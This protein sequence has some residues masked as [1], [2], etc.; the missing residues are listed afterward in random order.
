MA[1]T[2]C[3]LYEGTNLHA[4]PVLAGVPFTPTNLVDDLSFF[5]R[6]KEDNKDIIVLLALAETVWEKLPR[7]KNFVI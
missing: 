6:P 5:L 1:W 2:R 3:S 4:S 7:Q